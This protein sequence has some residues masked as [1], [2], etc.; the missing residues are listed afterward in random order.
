MQSLVVRVPYTALTPPARN[1]LDQMP[2]ARESLEWAR[3]ALAAIA[4]DGWL[5]SL[6]QVANQHDNLSL[7]RATFGTTSLEVSSLVLLVAPTT[8]TTCCQCGRLRL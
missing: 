7:D 1:R 2:D 8:L 3:H 5:L 6:R 4:G